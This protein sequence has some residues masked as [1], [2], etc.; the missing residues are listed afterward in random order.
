MVDLPTA[1]VVVTVTFNQEIDAATID[2]GDL[3][4]NQ[5]VVDNAVAID[6]N[7]DGVFVAAEYTISQVTD[8]G[9]WQIRLPKHAVSDTDGNPLEESTALRTLDVTT[10]DFPTPLVLVEPEASLIYERTETGIISSAADSDQFLL[11]VDAGQ[12]L[13]VVVRPEGD[14]TP[15]IAIP[16]LGIAA[17][18]AS[19]SGDSVILQ[20]LPVPTDTVLLDRVA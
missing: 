2:A 14:W 8:E 19:V 15:S 16:E 5:G 20:S 13:S 4:L 7:G 17:T 10:R 3:V 1:S 18:S 6:T 11:T 12:T 9:Q